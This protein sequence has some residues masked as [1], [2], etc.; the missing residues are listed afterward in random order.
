MYYS[1]QFIQ[2]LTTAIVFE[3]IYYTN[4]QFQD[5]T[6]NTVNT[7]KIN[8]KVRS[9]S[10][11][12]FVRS[13]LD[14]FFYYFSISKGV[15]NKLLVQYRLKIDLN[16][17]PAIGKFTIIFVIVKQSYPFFPILFDRIVLEK[18]HS[19]GMQI[20]CRFKFTLHFFFEWTLKSLSIRFCLCV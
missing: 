8:V 4:G 5:M 1:Y 18:M 20:I 13:Q 7:H 9:Y 6:D 16:L 2:W 19:K 12:C 11:L 3:L 15:K 14:D 10:K 17:N